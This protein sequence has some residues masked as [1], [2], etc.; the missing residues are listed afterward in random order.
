[1]QPRL[2]LLLAV[3]AAG[4]GS[5]PDLEKE[6]DTVRSWTATVRLA[7]DERR[8]HATTAA[9]TAQLRDKATQALD[10]AKNGIPQAA[11]SSADRKRAH[12]VVDSLARAVHLLDEGRG[13]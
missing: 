7:S 8:T 13:R 12:A 6:L 10:Q 11:H 9:Y 1:M 4:C 2:A 3:A 5:S